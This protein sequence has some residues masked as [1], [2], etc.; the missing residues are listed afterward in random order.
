[1]L[2]LED[3]WSCLLMVMSTGGSC[4]STLLHLPASLATSLE[5]GF[6]WL[7]TPAFTYAFARCLEHTRKNSCCKELQF[8]IRPTCPVRQPL[9]IQELQESCTRIAQKSMEMASL[10]LAVGFLPYLA[11]IPS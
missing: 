5:R 8:H 9:Y 3:A 2:L 4:R 11:G 7:L 6:P 10:S 1:M